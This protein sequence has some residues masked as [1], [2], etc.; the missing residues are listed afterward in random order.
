MNMV[1]SIVNVNKVSLEIM[2]EDHVMVS[3]SV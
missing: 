2:M 1:A 3:F